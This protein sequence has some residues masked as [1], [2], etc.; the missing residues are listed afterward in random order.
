MPPRTRGAA[1]LSLEKPDWTFRVFFHDDLAS[2]FLAHVVN[3]RTLLA[4]RRCCTRALSVVKFSPKEARKALQDQGRWGL[5][6]CAARTGDIPMIQF[7]ML[8]GCVTHLVCQ[9]AA[10]NGQLK[11][12]KYAREEL[13]LP[14]CIGTCV[15][16]ARYGQLECLD[17]AYNNHCPMVVERTANEAALN[18]H[19]EILKWLDRQGLP[20]GG[21]FS[22]NTSVCSARGG[23][24]H[25]L[26]WL[27]E[28][29]A[30]DLS[31]LMYVCAAHGHL[32]V[33]KWAFEQGGV[34]DEWTCACAAKSGSLECLQWLHANNCPWD[35]ATCL[36]AARN[37]HFE[38]LK[39]A[40]EN[41]CAWEKEEILREGFVRR[42][43]EVHAWV[44]QQND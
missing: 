22:R 10:A 20:Y 24:L 42:Q 5:P 25:C 35:D 4:L 18:G 29:S 1:A 27:Q 7:A 26:K 12:L 43:G 30:H 6:D 40:K 2:I 38:C 44:L 33:L 11:L 39:W 36:H 23:H 37:G 31:D 21:A 28:K 17:Y 8:K 41:G 32:N 3:M 19:L 15:R 14:W 16:A 34:F 9:T 13:G